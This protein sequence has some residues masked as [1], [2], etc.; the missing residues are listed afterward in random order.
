MKNKNI[1]KEMYNEKI[2]KE[3]NYQEIIRKIEKKDNR[4]KYLKL[5]IIPV[6][7]I[8]LCSF[9]V[10]NSN[11]SFLEEKR[12]NKEVIE[13]MKDTI[14]INN[15]SNQKGLLKIDG[16][17]KEANNVFIPYYDVLSNLNVPSYLEEKDY[18]IYVKS[19]PDINNYDKVIQY[20]KSF[21]NDDKSIEI[22]YS[23][24][25]EPV[26]DYLFQDGEVSVIN[27]FKLVIYKYENSYMTKFKYKDLFIDIETTNITE[28]Q[29]LNLIKSIIK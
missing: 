17:I 8:I 1:F 12:E 7:L 3:N 9:I 21:Y 16:N 13:T 6:C 25:N 22:N 2:N 15:M 27:N 28:E 26:R 19:N 4:F 10:I 29:F 23:Q 5:S 24:E 18:A 11:S 20:V 14:N